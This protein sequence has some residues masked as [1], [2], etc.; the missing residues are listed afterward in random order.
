MTDAS[1][2]NTEEDNIYPEFENEP[3]PDISQIELT[4]DTTELTTES[5]LKE[6]ERN[7]SERF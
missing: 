5:W 2:R 7:Q 1:N 4:N 6:R 3:L